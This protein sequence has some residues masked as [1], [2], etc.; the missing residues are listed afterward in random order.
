MPIKEN[1][2]KKENMHNRNLMTTQKYKKDDLANFVKNDI[3]S[4][5]RNSAPLSKF[6]EYIRRELSGRDV[7]YVPEKFQKIVLGGVQENGSFSPNSLAEFY[8]QYFGIGLTQTDRVRYMNSV[9]NGVMPETIVIKSEV[10]EKNLVFNAQN[11]FSMFH[12]ASAIDDLCTSIIKKSVDKGIIS[13]SE[14]D[15]SDTIDQKDEESLALIDHPSLILD[16]IRDF[17]NAS[18]KI[19]PQYNEYSMFLYSIQGVPKDYI[20]EAYPSVANE[21]STMVED[22]DLEIK[23]IAN[24]PSTSNYIEY[25][26]P[27]QEGMVSDI[28]ILYRNVFMLSYLLFSKT[29]TLFDGVMNEYSIFI[30]DATKSVN[31]ILD[32]NASTL[33]KSKER[34]I[35]IYI[36]EKGFTDGYN[37][38]F[39]NEHI[40]AISKSISPLLSSGCFSLELSYK[41]IVLHNNIVRVLQ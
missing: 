18:L 12:Y 32:S 2:I 3:V 26:F 21:F 28:V 36:D 4:L 9:R 14:S 37:P 38:V 29:N 10:S 13:S 31:G 16:M 34:E 11:T 23:R 5:K 22:L 40:S 35:Y 17:Y 33:A 25:M 15:A 24:L 30:S 1:L 20:T 8:S 19:L 6:G 41:T 7:L 27:R 39:P